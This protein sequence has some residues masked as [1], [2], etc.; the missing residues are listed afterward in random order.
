MAPQAE[1]WRLKA[2]WEGLGASWEGVG[3]GLGGFRAGWEG[4]EASWEVRGGEKRQKE[5]SA[6][7]C[8]PLF[9]QS[10]I[11]Y[12]GDNDCYFEWFLGCVHL[13]LVQAVFGNLVLVW[14][15]FVNQI[16]NGGRLRGQ[17]R[18]RRR[19][20]LSSTE[21]KS[22]LGI[23]WSVLIVESTFIGS[24][25]PTQQNQQ[26]ILMNIPQH[27]QEFLRAIRGFWSVHSSNDNL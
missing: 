15:P 27:L 4:L 1:G 12:F 25:S 9:Y 17:N 3:A 24:T 14:S 10:W 23:F 5:Q 8:A 19:R 2:S 18:S 21:S 26:L 11:S 16:N 22:M 20:P 6:V 7:L 13:K